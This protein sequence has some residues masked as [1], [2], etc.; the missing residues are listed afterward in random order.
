[1][2]VVEAL[3]ELLPPVAVAHRHGLKRK[4]HYQYCLDTY[5]SG[6]LFRTRSVN[7]W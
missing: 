3:E 6:G 5:H 7:A 2:V 1:M 4:S